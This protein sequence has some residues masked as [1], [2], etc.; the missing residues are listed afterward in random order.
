MPYKSVEKRT[1]WKRE[2]AKKNKDKIQEYAKRYY[3]KKKNSLPKSVRIK[4]TKEEIKE[5]DTVARKRRIQRNR[6]YINSIK[7]GNKCLKCG[8]SHISCLV[9]H[10][11]DRREK[12]YTISDMDNMSLETIKKEIEK[13]DM[14]CHNCHAKLHYEERGYAVT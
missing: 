9:F 12:E 13:C 6:E 3:D 10:H 1:E 11:R 5:T 7:Q 2:W 4:K 8:E 14:L